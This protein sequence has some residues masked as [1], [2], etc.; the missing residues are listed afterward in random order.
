MTFIIFATACFIGY[1][2][3]TYSVPET[4]N[5]SLEEIDE[6]FGS[7]VGLQ[8]AESKRQVCEVFL[9]EER[10]LIIFAV[11]DRTRAWVD[12]PNC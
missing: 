8:D 1:F 9:P 12:G 5:V 3:S 4:A 11:I 10:L 7:S 2:W 6:V